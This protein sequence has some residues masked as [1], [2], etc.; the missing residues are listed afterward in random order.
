MGR[1]SNDV[2]LHTSRALISTSMK[3]LSWLLRSY[4]NSFHQNYDYPGRLKGEP[5]MHGG[6]GNAGVKVDRVHFKK[7]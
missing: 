1:T 7:I 4:F 5:G 6:D 2:L 3:L